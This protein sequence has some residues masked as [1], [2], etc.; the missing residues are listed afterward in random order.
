MSNKKIGII[1]ADLLDGGTRHP[2]LT[3]LK[4]SGYHKELGDDVRLIENWDE[5][6]YGDHA[7]AYDHIYLAK[8]FDFTKVPI[9]VRAFPNLSYGGTGFYFLPYRENGPHMLPSQIEHHMPDYHL[10]DHFV[11]KE[12]ERG[13]KPIKFRDYMDYSI[14]FTTR[15][16]FRGCHFCV[17]ECSGGV[18]FH[19]HVKEFFDP[20]RKYIYL[21][22]DNILGYPKW[23]DVFKELEETGRRFQFRQGMDIRIMTEAKAEVLSNARYIGD[24]IF[25]F[26]HPEEREMIER[27][28]RCWK[29]F[30]HRIVKF[31]VL[32]GYDSQDAKDIEATFMRIKVLMKYGF[33]PYIM[34]YEKY[35][36]SPYRGTYI[37]LARWCNQPSFFKKKSYRQ[38]CEANGDSSST[39]RYFRKLEH[40]YPEIAQKYFDL[41]WEDLREC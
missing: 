17:N 20:S 2:N 35:R 10:Y 19:A 32:C 39:M 3:C 31:Y 37:N 12:I 4:L 16:C 25:A 7:N 22:D 21:W 40:D 27:G 33:L 29:K 30:N 9:D 24:Y 28:I 8:V 34:R 23:Q 41:R 6:T 36:E 14:G 18:K 38:F 26:D 1:D 15:G 11:Q 13:I 5:M